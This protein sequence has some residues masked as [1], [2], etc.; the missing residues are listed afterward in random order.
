MAQ[1]KNDTEVSQTAADAPAGVEGEQ[2]KPAADMSASELKA[3]LA[4][5]ADAKLH[6]AGDP[7]RKADQTSY[8]V[9]ND[10]QLDDPPLRSS[11]PDV[12]IVQS[13]ATGAVAHNA[14]DPEKYD[15]TGRPRA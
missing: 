13:L 5:P 11:R 10:A 1:N 3:S 7:K 15:A 2:V 6:P 4:R 12:G 9:P 14:P 8:P